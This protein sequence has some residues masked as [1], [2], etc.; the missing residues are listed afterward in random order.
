[1]YDKV[2]QLIDELGESSFLDEL[3]AAL[4]YDEIDG[5]CDYIARMWTIEFDED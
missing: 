4:T 2:N 3:L 5:A 1:M